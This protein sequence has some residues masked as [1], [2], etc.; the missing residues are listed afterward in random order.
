MGLVINEIQRK[1]TNFRNRQ[2]GQK[3]ISIKYEIPDFEEYPLDTS[4]RK[5]KSYRKDIIT[6]LQNAYMK[7][8]KNYDDFKYCIGAQYFTKT[9][10]EKGDMKIQ[11]LFIDNCFVKTRSTDLFELDFSYFDSVDDLFV[12]TFYVYIAKKPIVKKS[13][14]G[15]D[16][17]HNDCLFRAL[18][19][20]VNDRDNLPKCINRGHKLKQ[21]LGYE[22]DDLIDI[23][24]SLPALREIFKNHSSITV[25][26]DYE[27]IPKEKKQNNINLRVSGNHI[28]L[29]QSKSYFH[30]YSKSGNVLIKKYQKITIL[31][32]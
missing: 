22:R 15:K 8:N 32:K 18:V 6:S 1:L 5:Q 3:I 27:N 10:T 4:T 9:L 20:A 17:E 14:V 2:T 25:I 29:V 23:K 28:K 31:S 30:L 13:K 11:K 19:M 12:N 7:I 24:E 21:F 26:G 16:D